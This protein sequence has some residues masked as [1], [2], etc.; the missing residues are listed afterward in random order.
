MLLLGALAALGSTGSEVPTRADIDFARV[1]RIHQCF[2]GDG[3]VHCHQIRN[4]R[5]AFVNG[6]RALARCRYEEWAPANRW[7]RKTLILRRAGENWQWVS[8]DAP[9][10]SITVISEE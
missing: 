2:G 3:M 5:C 8:G 4:L 7:P 10:C 6:D 1:D 9:R